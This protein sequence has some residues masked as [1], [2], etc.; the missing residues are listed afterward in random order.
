MRG[1]GF[2]G[3]E[4]RF[5]DAVIGTEKSTASRAPVTPSTP[6]SKKRPK[7]IPVSVWA[8]ETFGVYA[9]CANT[10]RAWVRNGLIY[11]MPTKVGRGYFCSPDAGYFDPV[12]QKVR[13]MTGGL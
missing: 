8:E 5:V 3:Q 11:P 4:K 9:P 7:L 10:I 13:R 1:S 6:S 12:V 2:D